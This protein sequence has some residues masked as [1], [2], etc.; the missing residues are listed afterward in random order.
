[1]SE[2]SKLLSKGTNQGLQRVQGKVISYDSSSGNAVVQL[3]GSTQTH[4]YINKSGELLSEGD[5]VQV[6]YFTSIDAGFVGLR[7]GNDTTLQKISELEQRII[8]LEGK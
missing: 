3:V 5:S 6:W 1:M 8:A 2:L 7:C 4:T